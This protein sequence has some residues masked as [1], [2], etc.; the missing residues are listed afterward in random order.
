[1]N[2]HT[3]VSVAGHDPAGAAHSP[4]IDFKFD[5]VGVNV[6]ALAAMAANPARNPNTLTRRRTHQYD[7][8]PSYLGNRLGQ[9]LEPAIV[10]E[11]A[12]EDARIGAKENIQ[13]PA[14]G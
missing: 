13:R 4:P 9:F 6:T 1:M 5:Q 11:A 14:R 12:V 2:R 10:G 3:A 8:V 7:V